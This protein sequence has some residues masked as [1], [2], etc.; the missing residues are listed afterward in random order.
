MMRMLRRY[1]GVAAA[2]ALVPK[3]GQL[4]RERPP[5]APT[6]G[7]LPPPRFG[8]S[9]GLLCAVPVSFLR[10]GGVHCAPPTDPRKSTMM[11]ERWVYLEFTRRL[12]VIKKAMNQC[13]S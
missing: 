2:A 10:A 4:G 5:A 9:V 13:G 8:L 11:A 7:S 12:P 1:C 3:C 6:F